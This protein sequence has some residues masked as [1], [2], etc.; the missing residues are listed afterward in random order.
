MYASD[1]YT[2]RDDT[3]ASQ[4]DGPSPRKINFSFTKKIKLKWT[5]GP[6]TRYLTTYTTLYLTHKGKRDMI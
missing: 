5:Y 4:R 2:T 3:M 6:H 1:S